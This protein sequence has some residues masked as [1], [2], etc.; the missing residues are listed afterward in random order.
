MKSRIHVSHTEYRALEVALGILGGTYKCVAIK[1]RNF[2][3]A[4]YLHD[5]HQACKCK[6]RF[7][8]LRK[9]IP[10]SVS[11]SSTFHSSSPIALSP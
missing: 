11:A 1:A 3:I 6:Y 5:S 7:I 8:S 10:L 4:S 9:D 2:N